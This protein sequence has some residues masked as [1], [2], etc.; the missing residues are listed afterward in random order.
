MQSNLARDEDVTPRPLKR[1]RD[2]EIAVNRSAPASPARSDSIT[3]SSSALESHHSGR[4]SPVKLLLVLEDDN[5]QPVVFCNFDDDVEGEEPEDVT[6]MRTA[7]QS[8]ADGIGILG[9]DDGSA[10]LTERR[11]RL[12]PSDKTRLQYPWAND[13]QRRKGYGSM[14]SMN[15]VEDIVN[16]AR[17]KDRGG[18]ASEDDWNTEVHLQL[19]KLAR[20]TSRRK[21]TLD[22]HNVWVL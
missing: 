18:G 19:L 13:P 17:K 4:L 14:P 12:T 6:T 9:Y 2:V 21:D 8:F 3:T 20:K 7:I 16:T 1:R 5:E 22:I 15:E 11:D 10:I